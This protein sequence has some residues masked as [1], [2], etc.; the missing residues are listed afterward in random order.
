MPKAILIIDDEKTIRWSLGEALKE[1]GHEIFEAD[2]GERGLEEFRRS[3]IDLCLVDLKLPGDNG[4]EIL[5]KMKALDPSVP[6]IMMTA[7]GEVETAVEAMKNGAYDF[8]LKPFALEKLKV[9]IGNALETHRLKDEIAYLKEKTGGASVYKNFIGHSG[10]MKAI[11]HKLDKI[12][13]SKANT[14]LITG[15]SGAGKELVARTVHACSYSDTRP[16]MEIN[17]ASVPETLLESELFG[18]EKGAFTD[19]KN[20]KKGLV[21]LAEGGTL[22]LDEIGEMGITLQSRLL[23]VIENKTF[24]RVGGVQ[25]LRVNTRIVAATNRNLESAIEE[26]TFRKDLYYRL[27]VI[28]IHVPPLRERKEDIP[29][30]VNHFVDR[31]NRELGKHVKPVARDVMEV[32]INYDWPG[33]VR[34][35]KNVVERAMLLDAEEAILREHLP[36]EI[37]ASGPGTAGP[38]RAAHVLS[39][40]FPMTLREV[41]QIQILK[42]L[43]QTKGNKSKA[44]GILGISRQ[45]LREKLK[46][47]DQAARGGADS[48]PQAGRDRHK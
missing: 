10:P 16:F 29:F 23:R 45:T 47:V 4:I 41:E 40:F 39:S 42:T 20:R 21:E 18:Y 43:E 25:D 28:P 37:Y 11:F 46:L 19:A 32:L 33:N 1:A 9:T 26:K 17:C 14:V 30:L 5:K 3:E 27:K 34:E 15:E 7:Y 13:K 8:T 6:V 38:D 2:N 36:G 48:R 24:R 35:L 31:F 22:F 44:A 12:G